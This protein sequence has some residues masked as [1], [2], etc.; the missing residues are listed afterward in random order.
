MVTDWNGRN[1]KVFIVVMLDGPFFHNTV[2]LRHNMMMDIDVVRFVILI[3]LT[4]SL[5]IWHSGTWKI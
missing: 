2:Y 4:N 5:I 1:N 3:F